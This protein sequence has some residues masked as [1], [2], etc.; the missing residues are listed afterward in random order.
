[1]S[2]DNLAKA[3]GKL[4]HVRA[5]AGADV[6]AYNL[7]GDPALQARRRTIAIFLS[8]IAKWNDPRSR[9]QIVATHYLTG[10]LSVVPRYNGSGTTYI[11]TDYLSKISPEWNRRSDEHLCQLAGEFGRQR[12]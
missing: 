9:P 7:P 3:P 4:L 11:W 1:M 2:D 6:V 5:V 12:Q 8:Q 10:T